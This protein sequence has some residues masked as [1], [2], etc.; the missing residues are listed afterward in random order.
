VKGL[1]RYQLE[2]ELVEKGSEKEG[3]E[4]AFAAVK[5]SGQIPHGVPGECFYRETCQGIESFLGRLSSYKQG[6]MLEPLELDL[7]VGNS[8]L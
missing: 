4:N 8:E 2:Q 1:E 5:A 7:Q 6:E 3:L